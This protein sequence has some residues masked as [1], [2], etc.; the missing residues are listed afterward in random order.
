MLRSSILEALRA[1]FSDGH[2][3]KIAIKARGCAKVKIFRVDPER[4]KLES[5]DCPDQLVEAKG[6]DH[7]LGEQADLNNDFLEHRGVCGPEV[8]C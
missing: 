4:K 7:G 1:S 5:S 3:S 8:G 6:H 2:V